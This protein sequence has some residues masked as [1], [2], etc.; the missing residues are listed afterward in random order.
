[1]NGET[2]LGKKE[3]SEGAKSQ[4]DIKGGRPEKPDD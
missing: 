3:N 1:M 2:I 4:E